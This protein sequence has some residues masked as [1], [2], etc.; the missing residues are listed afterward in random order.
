MVRED[1]KNRRA[2]YLQDNVRGKSRK[3][4][5]EAFESFKGAIMIIDG[6]E[7]EAR[8]WTLDPVDF[9]DDTVDGPLIEDIGIPDSDEQV[10]DKNLS[11]EENVLPD[12]SSLEDLPPDPNIEDA[13]SEVK[14]ASGQPD[15]T[16]MEEI[17]LV[18]PE[19]VGAIVAGESELEMGSDLP[20]ADKLDPEIP[21][22]DEDSDSGE[23]S[24]EKTADID[25]EW[26]PYS[27]MPSEDVPDSEVV[28]EDVSPADAAPGTDSE[29]TQAP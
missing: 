20:K 11:S 21:S 29:P 5:L 8:E 24:A 13:S 10:L 12:S 27:E 4:Q 23:V 16:E 17:K 18:V 19:N 2:K 1:I 28:D 22:L 25:E 3:K 7:V 9:P 6:E 15:I 14:S 26:V